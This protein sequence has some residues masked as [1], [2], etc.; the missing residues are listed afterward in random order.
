VPALPDGI[1]IGAHVNSETG[2]YYGYVKD[3]P[4][5]AWQELFARFPASRKVLWLLFGNTATPAFSQSNVVDLRGRTGFLD[6]LATIRTR[7]RIL[8]A[9]DSG[10]LTAA[11]YLAD[12]FP[13]EVVSLWS[14]PRQGILKQDCPSPNPQ[15]RHVPLQGR[16]EDVRNLAVD[17]VDRAVAAALT[18]CAPV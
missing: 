2:Q 11:Y 12:D 16:D 3:W 5:A 9:P 13:L 18:R 10:V 1:V 8:V 4:V 17:D 7:C 6:L 14:D 15:L